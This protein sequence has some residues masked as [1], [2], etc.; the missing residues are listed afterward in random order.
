MVNQHIVEGGTIR[1][2]KE[3]ADT[4]VSYLIDHPLT[5]EVVQKADY[6]AE[7]SNDRM[8]A[9]E[10]IYPLPDGYEY[11]FSSF[12]GHVI[13]VGRTGIRLQHQLESQ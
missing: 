1:S 11:N 5:D 12:A 2:L 6:I 3:F 13:G 10:H 9:P 8:T 4:A 7:L